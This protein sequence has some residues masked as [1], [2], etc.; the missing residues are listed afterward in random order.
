[1]ELFEEQILSMDRKGSRCTKWPPKVPHL[2][3]FSWQSK[4]ASSF[5]QLGA[6]DGSTN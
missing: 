6:E 3:V 4:T 1:M 2:W 5:F